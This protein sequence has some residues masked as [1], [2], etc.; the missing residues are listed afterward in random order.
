MNFESLSDEMVFLI[1]ACIGL[2]VG[3]ALPFIKLAESAQRIL[4][5]ASG[6]SLFATALLADAAM[7]SN[8]AQECCSAVVSFWRNHCDR[9]VH[10][11][12]AWFVMLVVWYVVGY[13]KTYRERAKGKPQPPS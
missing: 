5:I 3:A 4:V 10:L 6:I 8:Y 11:L 7:N 12:P 13:S 2:V 9:L 1:G